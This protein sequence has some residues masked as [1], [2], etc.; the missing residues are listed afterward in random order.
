[1]VIDL[2]GLGMRIMD[3]WKGSEIDFLVKQQIQEFIFLVFFNRHCFIKNAASKATVSCCLISIPS[4]VLTSLLNFLLSANKNDLNYQQIAGKSPL[5]CFFI[6]LS[7]C[8]YRIPASSTKRNKSNEINY[9]TGDAYPVD[10][11]HKTYIRRSIYVL[12]LLVIRRDNGPSIEEITRNRYIE[13]MRFC[14]RES[15]V[16]KKI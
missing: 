2:N 11:G 12:C 14:V 3:Q 9:N 5:S 15:P 10:T 4:C 7:L 6:S 16:R 13:K 1:M 8:C